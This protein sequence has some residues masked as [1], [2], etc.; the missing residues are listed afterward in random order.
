MFRGRTDHILWDVSMKVS[1]TEWFLTLK[2]KW[3]SRSQQEMDG[4]QTVMIW[5]F[6]EDYLPHRCGMVRSSLPTPGP[7]GGEERAVTRIPKGR[8]FWEGEGCPERNGNLSV[9]G[10]EQPGASSQKGGTRKSTLISLS[11]VLLG[12][13]LSEP[14]GWQRAGKCCC[15]L[16]VSLPGHAAGQTRMEMDQMGQT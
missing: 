4:A 14:A 3:L 13:P 7:Q 16:L 1:W 8:S 15:R 5:R 11:Q 9:V 2:R 10:Q 6:N 12:F